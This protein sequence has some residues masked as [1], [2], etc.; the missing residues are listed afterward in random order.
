MIGVIAEAADIQSM[1][2]LLA[3]KRKKACASSSFS[4]NFSLT[5]AEEKMRARAYLAQQT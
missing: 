5:L 3:L 1:P 4:L 2:S